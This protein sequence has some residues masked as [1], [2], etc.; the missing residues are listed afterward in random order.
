MA[1]APIQTFPVRDRLT[2]FLTRVLLS[3]RKAVEQRSVPPAPRRREH[4]FAPEDLQDLE[5]V[6][7]QGVIH[8]VVHRAQGWQARPVLVGSSPWAARV[9]HGPVWGIEPAPRLV[10]SDASLKLGVDVYNLCRRQ[11]EK[12]DKT[13]HR[14]ALEALTST[15]W[16]ASG[17]AL[18]AY[19]L[20]TAAWPQLGATKRADMLRGLTRKHALLGLRHGAWIEATP[21]DEAIDAAI[22]SDLRPWLPWMLDHALGHWRGWEERIWRGELQ[23]HLTRRQRQS[24]WMDAWLRAIERTGWFDLLCPFLDHLRFCLR[25]LAALAVGG[26]ANPDASW[27]DGREGTIGA[28]QM[29]EAGIARFRR[30]FRRAREADRMQAREAWA[31]VLL[32]GR[33]VQTMFESARS[34]HPIDR[35]ANHTLL[36]EICGADAGLCRPRPRGDAE[37]VVETTLRQLDAVGRL[38]GGRLG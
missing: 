27:R 11:R 9:V 15:R 16:Q 33:R 32:M 4:L 26:D 38:I 19:W 7:G 30:T 25:W 24:A 37:G 18:L 12:A 17:D 2:P 23:T 22:A 34:L 21:D 10:F 6:Y 13:I 3:G 29:A 5:E 28:P 1:E 20:L 31:E 35:E 14:W 36:I 8:A